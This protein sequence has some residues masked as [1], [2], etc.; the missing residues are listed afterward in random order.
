MI[1]ADP[2][3]SDDVFKFNT[4]HAKG[5]CFSDDFLASTSWDVPIT[6]GLLVL[7]GQKASCTIL[8]VWIF[9]RY[10]QGKGLARLKTDCR[11]L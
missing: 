1:N 6:G 3:Q 2:D 8:S 5:Y 9:R 7:G 11:L 4:E 10:R